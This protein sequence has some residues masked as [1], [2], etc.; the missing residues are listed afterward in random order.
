MKRKMCSI[1][2]LLLIAVSGAWAQSTYKVT[3]KEVNNI[4][5]E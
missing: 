2:L 3:M 1:L 5:N 4:V